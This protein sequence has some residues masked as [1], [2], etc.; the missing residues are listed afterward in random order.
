M[1]LALVLALVPTVAMAAPAITQGIQGVVKDAVTGVP[2]PFAEVHID[3]SGDGHIDYLTAD[4]DGTYSIA[5]DPDDYYIEAYSPRH[6]PQEFDPVN[7]ATDTVTTQDFSLAQSTSTPVQPIYR[8]F[9][10]K[11]G[12]HFYTA[13]DEEF[14]NVYENLSDVFHYDGIAYYIPVGDSEDPNY[15]NPNTMPLYRFFNRQT[16]VHFYTM[17]EQ[18]KTTVQSTLAH[19]YTYEG[20]AYFV[21]D[22]IGLP[23]YRFYVP[24]R[25]AHFFTTNSGEINMTSGLSNYYHF[26]GIGYYTG[27]WVYN[28]EL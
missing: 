20:V 19:M 2:V 28:P 11:G 8:F 23:V 5:L 9:N 16:G 27:D 14:I 24:L 10:M 26:E 17:S 7:V 12:V 6:S 15:T 1:V 4:F 22:S 25:N 3:Y 21:S 18:E 13:S